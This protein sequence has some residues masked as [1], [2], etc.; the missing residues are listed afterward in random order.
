MRL[1][2]EGSLYMACSKDEFIYDASEDI[3][4]YVFL[5]VEMDPRTYGTV[6]LPIDE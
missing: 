6:V 3:L 4:A 5:A 2:E 1:K